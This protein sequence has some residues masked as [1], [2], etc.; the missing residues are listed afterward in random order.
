[1]EN[2][3]QIQAYLKQIEDYKSGNKVY[4]SKIAALN[5][6]LHEAM[7][8]QIEVTATVVMLNANVQELTLRHKEQLQEMLNKIKSLEDQLKEKE[9]PKDKKVA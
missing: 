9:H 5:H 8:K 4:E 6:L 1:M 2:Q 3:Q 7:N